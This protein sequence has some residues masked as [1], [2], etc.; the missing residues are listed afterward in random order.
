MIMCLYV[1][2]YKIFLGV[3]RE[4]K[5]LF[6]GGVKIVFGNLLWEFYK[7]VFFKG[8]GGVIFG[9]FKFVYGLSKMCL[10]LSRFLRMVM[11]IFSV[12]W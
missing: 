7:F 10:F 3:G 11:L 8:E 5:K 4:R 6:L 9:F 12:L 1:W 2:I